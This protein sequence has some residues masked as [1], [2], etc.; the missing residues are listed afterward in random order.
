MASA[1]PVTPSD[2]ILIEAESMESYGGWVIDQQSMASMGSPYL[3]AHGMGVP[4]MDASTTVS[5]EDGG[6]YHL[7]VRTRD[8][9]RTWGRKES[10]GRFQVLINGTPAPETLG[11]ENAKW[12]WQYGGKVTLEEGRN[13]ISLHDLTGFNG[14]CDAIYLS[15]S[16]KFDNSVVKK[17]RAPKVK[18]G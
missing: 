17:L 4:V 9:T 12:H 15:R 1:G 14:R 16:K 7:W 13:V 5:S 8:W 2:D 11:T 3:M 6:T 18:A 10:P